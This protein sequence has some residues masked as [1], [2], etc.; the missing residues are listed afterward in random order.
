MEHTFPNRS[1][2]SLVELLLFLGFFA[3]TSGVVLALLFSS[4][5]Q[6]V[7]QNT[8]AEV[9]QAGI[10]LLQ[11]VT[12]R[13][14]RAERILFPAMASTGAVLTLQMTSD[15]ENPTLFGLLSGALMVG[16]GNVLRPLTD[17]GSLQAT[18]FTATNTSVN[19]ERSSV[20]ITFTIAKSIALP[21]HPLYTRTFDALVTLFP[22][23]TQ[24]GTCGCSAPICSGTG[25]FTWGY[26]NGGS[27]SPSAFTL[28]C[29]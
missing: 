22:D 2:T 16:E 17:S 10:Q 6:R 1:G 7:R 21:N 15:T 24:D 9:D 27:C 29:S 28:P 5:E 23:D 13:V 12:R 11:T 3:L 14:R 4:H 19:T 20:Y 18:Q 8:V 26:C 25:M